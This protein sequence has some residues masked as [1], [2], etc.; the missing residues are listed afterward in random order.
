[1]RVPKPPLRRH[2]TTPNADAWATLKL[3]LPIAALLFVLLPFLFP[4]IGGFLR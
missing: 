3:G 1:M 2:K 4:L